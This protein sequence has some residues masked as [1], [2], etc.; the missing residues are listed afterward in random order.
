MTYGW[1]IY[2]KG[3]RR[4]MLQ[5]RRSDI[6]AVETPRLVIC[7]IHL[8]RIH[9]TFP[10]FVFGSISC[11]SLCLG[12][13]YFRCQSPTKI[14]FCFF[15]FVLSICF[16]FIFL[17]LWCF[18]C[19]QIILVCPFLCFSWFSFCLLGFACGVRGVKGGKYHFILCLCGFYPFFVSVSLVLVVVFVVSEADKYCSP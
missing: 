7:S 6:F 1:V 18:R 2:S 8:S 14:S 15:I 16:C 10:V 19:G 13:L 4:N 12:C 3:N 11:L 9:M 17:V 5:W